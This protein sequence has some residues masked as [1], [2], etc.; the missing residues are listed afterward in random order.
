MQDFSDSALVVVGHGAQSDAAAAAPIYQHAAE[1]RRRR[2]FGAVLEAFWKQEP[3]LRSAE[4]AAGFRRV[5]VVPFFLS[6]G[7]FSERVIPEAL[8]FKTG[9]GPGWSRVQERG[10]QT[11]FYC[12]PVGSDPD[13]V[14]IALHRAQEVVEK[15][16]FPRAPIPAKTSL[17]IAGHGTERDENSRD[18]I[19]RVVALFI[20]KGLYAQVQAIYLEEAP[21]ISACYEL[22]QTENIV[23]VPFFAGEGPHV[24]EDIPLALGQSAPILQRRLESR[25]TPWRNPT[26]KKGKLVWYAEPV[27]TDPRIADIMLDLVRDAGQWPLSHRQVA[28]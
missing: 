28:A 18:T 21:R 14:N 26:E 8:G 15:S 17:F 19:E 4:A 12:K 7:Y 23:V 3:Q 11:L 22:A 6:A 27:G 2:I 24:K 16:P 1:L 9:L 13:L 5:F 20:L 25:Q 10:A